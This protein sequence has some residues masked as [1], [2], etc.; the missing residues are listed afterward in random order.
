[1]PSFN[2]SI[3]ELEGILRLM[4]SDQCDIDH[5]AEYTRRASRLIKECR[6]RLTA[7]EEELR[8][9]LSTLEPEK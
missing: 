1:M 5:L 4:Q 8:A 2:E 3:K 9:I 6:G 7:T